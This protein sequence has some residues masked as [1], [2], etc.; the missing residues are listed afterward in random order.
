VLGAI[1]Q[2][3]PIPAG[4]KGVTFQL[5]LTAGSTTLR[6]YLNDPGSGETHGAYYV[7]AKRL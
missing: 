3:I 4:A 7:Y 1:D 6:T 2:T 5:A